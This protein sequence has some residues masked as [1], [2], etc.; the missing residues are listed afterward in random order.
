MIHELKTWPEPFVAVRSGMKRHE[1]RNCSDRRYAL[2]DI[3]QLRE[4]NPQTETYTGQ[5]VFARV[6]YITAAGTF[7]LPDNICVMTIRVFQ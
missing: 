2:G 1:V 5:E 4:W 7:G 6:T 3:L